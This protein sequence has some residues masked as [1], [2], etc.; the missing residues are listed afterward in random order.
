MAHTDWSARNVRVWPDGIRA[1]YDADS[2]SLVPE[3]TA[4]GIA[5]ATWSAFGEEAEA[6][7][8]GPEEAARWVAAYEQADRPLSRA[9][10]HAAGGSVLYSL[11]YTARCEHAVEMLHPELGRPRRRA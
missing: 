1:I 4:V 6:T 5:A 11:A 2:L 9:Q 3:S 10:W 7:A 8:P